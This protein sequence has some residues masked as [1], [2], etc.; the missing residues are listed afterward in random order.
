[1]G[2]DFGVVPS[3]SNGCVTKAIPNPGRLETKFEQLARILVLL[4][5]QVHL[6]SLDVSTRYSCGE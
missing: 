5:L 2:V 4:G 3:V 1:M 6:P